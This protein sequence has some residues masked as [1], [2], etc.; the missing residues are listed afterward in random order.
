MSLLPI[1]LLAAALTPA[2]PANLDK[3]IGI[4]EHLNAQLPLELRFTDQTGRSVRLGDY[5]DGAR[6]T[7]LVLAYYE[8]PMLCGLVLR[9]VVNALRQ[10]DWAPGSQFR[11]VTVSFDPRDTPESAA[12]KQHSVVRGVGDPSLAQQW[13]FL[14]GDASTIKSLTDALGFRYR[15][16]DATEQF[17]HPSAIF[18]LTPEGRVSRYL[19]GVSFPIRD[20]KLAL[21]EAAA[22]RSG[23]SFDRFLMTCFH[24]DPATRR[25]GLYLVGFFRAGSALLLTVLCVAFV[26]LRRQERREG[27]A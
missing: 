21:V 7:V 14:V 27:P 20:F 17:A 1:V 6:P 2:T 15:F 4:D 23:L 11:L 10:L 22:H 3:E 5:A 18:I 13:P 12:K 19:Y 9:G 8:C 16:D 24:Y 26:R 25:Y